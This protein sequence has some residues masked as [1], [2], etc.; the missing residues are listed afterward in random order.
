MKKYERMA[1]TQ[2]D[3]KEMGPVLLPGVECILAPGC[4]LLVLLLLVLLLFDGAH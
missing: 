3:V 2:K 4:I 1:E